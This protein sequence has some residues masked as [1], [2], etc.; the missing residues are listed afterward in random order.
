MPCYNGDEGR[1]CN[2]YVEKD[3]QISQL[4]AALCAVL[5]V[6]DRMN[7]TE[8]VL[9]RVNYREAGGIP[10]IR[11]WWLFHKKEDAERLR[12]ENKQKENKAIIEAKKKA[13][14]KLTLVERKLLGIRE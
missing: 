4:K 11:R 5:T 9:L 12:L 7:T 1:N 14:D 6:T 10:D 13:L 2:C 3:K 8:D